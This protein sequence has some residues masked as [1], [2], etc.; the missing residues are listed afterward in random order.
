VTRGSIEVKNVLSELHV[1][2]RKISPESRSVASGVAPLH[3]K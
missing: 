2:H 1:E 3:V